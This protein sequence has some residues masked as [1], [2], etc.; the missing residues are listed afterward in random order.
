MA[1]NGCLVVCLHQVNH[2]RILPA[3]GGVVHTQSIPGTCNTE[4]TTTSSTWLPNI[5]ALVMRLEACAQGNAGG[6]TMH[7]R[8]A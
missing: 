3:L 6:S 7:G 4:Q 1:S 8:G 5:C 2:L